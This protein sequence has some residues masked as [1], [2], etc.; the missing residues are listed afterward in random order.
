V[1]AEVCG[2]FQW[3]PAK[4]GLE[5]LEELFGDHLVCV[6]PTAKEATVVP[7][8]LLDEE[9]LRGLQ[10]IVP[11]PMRG[12]FGKA[13]EG[14][15]SVRCKDNVLAGWFAVV[16]FDALGLADQ[17]K[18]I[19]HLG[20]RVRL[21]M[22]VFSGNKSY[23]SWFDVMGRSSDEVREFMDYAIRVGACPSTKSV[24]QFVRIPGGTNQK[25]GISQS[26]IHFS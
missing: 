22:I 26:V 12:R 24:C 6:G 19:W 20:Q 17:L 23:H 3:K 14:H 8:C 16:E 9:T 4:S 7:C 15:A 1:L 25:T 21:R 10:F 13:Q 18:I 5:C 2:A 11:N